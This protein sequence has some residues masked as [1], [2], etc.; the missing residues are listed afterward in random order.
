[1]HDDV[2]LT[3]PLAAHSTSVPDGRI[4]H[5][6]ELPVSWDLAD[7]GVTDPQWFDAAQ[8]ASARTAVAC[9]RTQDMLASVRDPLTL[10]RFWANLIGAAERTAYRYPACPSRRRTAGP[11]DLVPARGSGRVNSAWR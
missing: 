10:G 11:G 6:K 4:G 3:N 5:D 7:A 8:L 1:M 9:P 2:G